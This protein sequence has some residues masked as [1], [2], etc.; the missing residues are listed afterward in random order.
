MKKFYTR[1]G[2]EGYTGLLGKERVAKY[3]PKIVAIG[4]IDEASAAL[5]LARSHTC[6]PESSS[7]ILSLQRDLYQLMGEIAA[8][9]DNSERFRTIDAE[10]VNW[11][12]M[13][14]DHFANTIEMPKEFIIPGD[15]KAGAAL[16]LAR[17]IIRRAER[18][19]AVLLHNK[20]IENHDLFRY[21]NRASSLCFILELYE[22]SISGV[23]KPESVK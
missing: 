3:H 2:D 5:G 11:L 15:T 12:E 8:S 20:E 6:S 14:V 7:V 16:A 1:K 4:A 19:T 23:A 21:L 18:H 9:K 22:Y 17:T 10:K 13:Q